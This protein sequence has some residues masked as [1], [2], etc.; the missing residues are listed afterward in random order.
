MKLFLVTILFTFILVILNFFCKKSN[1]LLDKKKL[2]H[3]LFVSKDKT[4]LTGGIILFINLIF[5][6][7][8][9][10]FLIF[11]FLI[12]FLGILSDLHKVVSPVKKIIVQ[13]IIVFSSLYFLDLNILITKVFFIDIFIK[14]KIFSML[15]T[16]FC[17]IVLINGTNFIDGIN[18]L[19]CGYYMLV[20]IAILYVGS[21]NSLYFNSNIYYYLL[22]SLLT[23][24]IF[25]LFSKNYLGDSG[26]FLLPF[27]IGFYLISFCNENLNSL[28][29]VSPIFVLLLLWYPA[30][31]LLFSIIR[32]LICK[33]KLTQPDN[34]HFH[35]LLFILIKSKFKNLIKN[36][37]INS[38]SANLINFFNLII[39]IFASKIYF[40]T[41]YLSY[42]VLFNIFTYCIFYYL[43][44]KL[45]LN[46]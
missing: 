43:F 14:N 2:P 25:N 34:R 17:L 28:K 18:T 30:F 36:N 9:I 44:I 22:L 20:I 16:T 10:I 1:F 33:I 35:Q 40:H 24:Y 23:I 32:R 3:K 39:F 6:N 31:E 45:D 5:F 29:P 11:S 21:K 19:V 8:N 37:Y 4:P 26:S 7:N 42:L 12:F 15:F 41:Q 46:K 38:F 27:I 13:F